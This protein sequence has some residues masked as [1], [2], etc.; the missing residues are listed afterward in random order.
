[1]WETFTSEK[2]SGTGYAEWK[3]TQNFKN[4]IYNKRFVPGTINVLSSP[5]RFKKYKSSPCDFIAEVMYM[6]TYFR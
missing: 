4:R 2:D 5:T 6:Q 3:P 1:L